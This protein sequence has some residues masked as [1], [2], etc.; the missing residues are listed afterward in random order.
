MKKE[1]SFGVFSNDYNSRNVNKISVHKNE[2]I[3]KLFLLKNF[4]TKV[5]LTSLCLQKYD[6]KAL[7][8]GSEIYVLGYFIDY[9]TLSVVKYCCSTKT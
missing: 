7:S 9:S 4:D 6:C 3:F 2:S 8:I 1:F 5:H